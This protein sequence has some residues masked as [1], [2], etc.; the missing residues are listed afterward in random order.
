MKDHIVQGVPYGWCSGE[1]IMATAI[2]NVVGQKTLPKHCTGLFQASGLTSQG[3]DID[4][5]QQRA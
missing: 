3:T 2:G 1:N 4:E 5:R